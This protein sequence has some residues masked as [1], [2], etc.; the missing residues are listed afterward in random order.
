MPV[1]L[2]VCLIAAFWSP[3]SAQAPEL[4]TDRPD[5]TESS[6]IVPRGS[7]QVESGWTHAEDDEDG[8]RID[9]DAA[10]DTL[11]RIGMARSLELRV[12]FGGYQWEEIRL[13]AGMGGKQDGIADGSLGF[14]LKFGEE[15]GRRPEMALLAS[16]SLPAGDSAFSSDRADPSFRITFANTINERLSIGYNAGAAW[17]T[18]EDALGVRHTASVAEWTVA[19]GIAG[20]D[21][22]GF[23]VELFGEAALSA[24]GS[25]SNSFDG[26]ATY[27]LR[28]NLQL[29]VAGGFG[30][31]DAAEDW[32]VGI[33][34]S[35]R[36]PR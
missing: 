23:F 6:A 28:D 36:Y 25:P 10:P 9:S 22:V 17:S 24:E 34:V 11:L 19:L 32:F 33:G 35:Y 29:D 3:A 2:P 1:G 5:Q 30:L 7:W 15:D 12:G 4:I 20:T 26:G 18:E 14:K 8:V 16:V 27:L 31:T 21:R 13:P